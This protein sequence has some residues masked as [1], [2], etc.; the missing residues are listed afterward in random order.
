MTADKKIYYAIHQLPQGKREMTD[1]EFREHIKEIIKE[2][3]SISEIP[4]FRPLV[5]LKKNEEIVYL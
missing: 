2:G 4:C 5:D 3:G 1:E